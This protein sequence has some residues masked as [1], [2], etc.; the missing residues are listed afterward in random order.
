M[1]DDGFLGEVSQD[2][3]KIVSL[4]MSAYPSSPPPPAKDLKSFLHSIFVDAGQGV[5]RGGGWAYLG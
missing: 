3:R 5:A 4:V 2:F 1:P